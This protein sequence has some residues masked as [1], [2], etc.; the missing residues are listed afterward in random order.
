VTWSPN[1]RF[2]SVSLN[3]RYI[4][5]TK[6]TNNESNPF[7]SGDPVV[8]NSRIKAYNYFDLATTVKPWRK[9]ELRAGVNNLFDKS[10]PAIAAGLLSVFGNGNTY[11]GVYDPLGRYV[12]A[13]ASIEF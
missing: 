10:P 13:G 3:W 8:I 12:F 1:S 4:G 2:A 5:G 6:I 9:L 11:P 7:L